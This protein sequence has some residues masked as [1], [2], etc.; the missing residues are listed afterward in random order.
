MATPTKREQ[1]P[2]TVEDPGAPT[3]GNRRATRAIAAKATGSAPTAARVQSPRKSDGV[4]LARAA[5]APL[6]TFSTSDRMVRGDGESAASQNPLR[7]GL[8]QDRNPAAC[9]MVI[10]GVSGDL[11]SRKL[12]PSLYDLAVRVPLPPGFSIVGISRRDWSPDDFR[13]EM[14]EAIAKGARR[15]V[16]DEGWELFAR[17]IFYVRGDFGEAATFEAV[18][19][20]LDAIDRERRTLGNRIFYLATAPQYFSPIVHGLSEAGALERQANYQ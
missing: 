19:A 15:T 1:E 9:A 3:N 16:D 17:G 5:E 6:P 20:R 18:H 12:M 13:A 8:A 11:T 4:T 2:K 7:I 14:K 10:F